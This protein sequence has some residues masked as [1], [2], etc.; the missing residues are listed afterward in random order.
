MNHFNEQNNGQSEYVRQNNGQW[1][2]VRS[3]QDIV[4]YG[5]FSGNTLHKIEKRISNIYS[6]L[7]VMILWVLIVILLL[8][9][10][11]K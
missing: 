1:Y 11:K 10:I 3:C 6:L 9:I 2:R 5:D 4:Y 7:V 8:L